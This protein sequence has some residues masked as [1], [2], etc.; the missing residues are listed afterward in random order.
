MSSEGTE[1]LQ[2]T[3]KVDCQVSQQRGQQMNFFEQGLTVSLLSWYNDGKETVRKK[4]P[5]SNA[6]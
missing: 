2:V 5:C 4:S 6:Y 3:V 1:N